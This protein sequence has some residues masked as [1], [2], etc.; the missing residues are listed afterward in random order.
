[1]VEQPDKQPVG[2]RRHVGTETS[3]AFYFMH[4]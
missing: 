1:M 4:S 2:R 3:V